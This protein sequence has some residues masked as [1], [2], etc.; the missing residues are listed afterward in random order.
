MISRVARSFELCQILLEPVFFCTTIQNSFLN[1]SS[2]LG[3]LVPHD[4]LLTKFCSFCQSCCIKMPNILN[5]SKL[6]GNLLSFYLYNF[7]ASIFS[8][9]QFLLFHLF[10]HASTLPRKIQKLFYSHIENIGC[11]L[12]GKK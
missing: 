8:F 1:I 3:F 9:L 11:A 12:I 6:T 4:K 7:T 5:R 2:S 10:V